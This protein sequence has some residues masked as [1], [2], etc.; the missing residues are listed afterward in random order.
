MNLLLL[1][2]AARAEPIVRTLP[3]SVGTLS[4]ELPRG[5]LIVSHDSTAA[6][7]LLTV[8][9]MGWAAGC[10]LSLSG[11]QQTATAQVI[12]DAG[13]A[14]VGCRSRVEVVLAGQTALSAR[15]SAGSVSTTAT[16]GVQSIHVGTGRVSGSIGG[17]SVR[18]DQ[19][20]VSLGALTEGLDVSVNVGSIELTYDVPPRGPLT[21]RSDMGN[22]TV[23][24]PA[25]AAIVPQV[26]SNV[27]IR[28]QHFTSQAGVPVWVESQLGSARLLAQGTPTSASSQPTSP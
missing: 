20:R 15:I 19:G 21:A 26:R 16:P 9:P 27:G 11:D 1:I 28:E 8:T 6:A 14:A 22:V 17:G 2:L 5:E 13:L 10:G 18:V 23:T 25:D 12:H 4:L 24:L 3:T 7:T